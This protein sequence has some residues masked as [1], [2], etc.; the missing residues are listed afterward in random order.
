MIRS[1]DVWQRNKALVLELHEH[2]ILCD[3]QCTHYGRVVRWQDDWPPHSDVPHAGETVWVNGNKCTVHSGI[4]SGEEHPGILLVTARG[5]QMWTLIEDISRTPPT[6]RAEGEVVGTIEVT[7]DKDTYKI[8][9]HGFG[10]GT[11]KII[12]EGK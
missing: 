2:N 8:N 5:T 4:P 9:A 7:E 12:K 1:A 3:K 11:Y 10:P 6:Q